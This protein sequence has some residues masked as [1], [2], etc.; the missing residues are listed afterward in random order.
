MSSVHLNKELPK[1][2][3]DGPSFVVT[4]LQLCSSSPVCT[5]SAGIGSQFLFFWF[6]HY[7]AVTE[8]CDQ[9]LS[10]NSPNTCTHEVIHVC[11]T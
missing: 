4:E 8:E 10:L 1:L 9:S 6:L 7:N 5:P 3:E 2:I 11:G